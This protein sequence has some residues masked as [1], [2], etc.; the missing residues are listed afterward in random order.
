MRTC[1]RVNEGVVLMRVRLLLKN[2][3]TVHHRPALGCGFS[4][5]LAE[6]MSRP[7]TESVL[8]H[9]GSLLPHNTGAPDVQPERPA[10][11]SRGRNDALNPIVW[12]SEVQKETQTSPVLKTY[13]LRAPGSSIKMSMTG[14]IAE[15]LGTSRTNTNGASGLKQSGLRSPWASN[16]CRLLRL[17][18]HSE[19]DQCTL[20]S[21][22]RHPLQSRR[23]QKHR[24]PIKPVQLMSKNNL[25]YWS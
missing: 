8:L 17:A 25:S 7:I 19:T 20:P 6:R 14:F 2:T 18:Q 9:C 4:E 24:P 11:S 10:A 23:Q 15:G 1:V 5:C 12:N 22:K 16:N 21:L 3:G 13:F